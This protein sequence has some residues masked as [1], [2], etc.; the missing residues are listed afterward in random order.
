[1]DVIIIDETI[2]ARIQSAFR[3]PPFNKATTSEFDFF[4]SDND[5]IY[6]VRFA[7]KY[8]VF[9]SKHLKSNPKP[10]IFFMT[11][12]FDDYFEDAILCVNQIH[13]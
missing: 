8:R 12:V 3:C 9:V 2:L 13:I 4:S 7:N 10:F 1:M 6:R 11:G 5:F